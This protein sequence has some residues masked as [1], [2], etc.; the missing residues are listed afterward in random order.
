[1]TLPNDVARC[2]GMTARTEAMK[3]SLQQATLNIKAIEIGKSLPA[4]FA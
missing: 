3:A 1:M 4:E 2:H